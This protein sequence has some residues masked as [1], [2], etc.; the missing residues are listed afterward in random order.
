MDKI[1]LK[2]GSYLYYDKGKFDKWCVYQV[3]SNGL[4]KAPKDV[5]YF[6]ELYEYCDI[7]ENEEIYDDFVKI[8][9]LTTNQINAD[10]IVEIRNLS[11]KYGK[12]ED[13]IFRIF[14]TI[15]MGMIA[16]ENKK[17]TKLGKRIKRLGMYYLLIKNELPEYCSTFMTGKGWKEI[18][19]LC[20]EGGF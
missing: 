17:N 13:E 6:Q 16:E 18:D 4:R 15:Y 9:D 2:D 1:D 7:F 10:V 3:D 5:D 14:S 12:F 20:L 11:Q 19:S 8:Y